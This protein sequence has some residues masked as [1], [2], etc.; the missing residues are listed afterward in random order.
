MAAPRLRLAHVASRNGQSED[1][2]N[3]SIAQYGSIEDFVCSYRDWLTVLLAY[4]AT[5]ILGHHPGLLNWF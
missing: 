2:G 3:K 4:R 5:C 1:E